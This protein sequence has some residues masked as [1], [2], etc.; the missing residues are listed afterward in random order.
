MK[1]TRTRAGQLGALSAALLL[2]A[3][4]GAGCS[5]GEP[6]AAPKPPEPAKAA[7][8]AKPT[9]ATEPAKP[10]APAKALTPTTVP[11]GEWLT[12]FD[13]KTLNGWK[14]PKE[15]DFS[16]AGKVEIK[17]GSLILREGV[18]FTGIAWE[19]AF[20]KE[21]FEIAYE[22]KRS[23]GIDIF[24]GCTVPVGDSHVTFVCG[25]WGD[26][27]VGLSSIDDRN[28]SDNEFTKV[29]SFKNDQWYSM[30]L[31]VTKEKI[32]AWIDDTQ[33]I[34]CKRE[35]HKFSIYPEL[36]PCRPV[37]FFSWSTEGTL[38][39]IDMKRLKAEK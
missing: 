3:G 1:M 27:V 7:E 31:R 24:C 23:S 9:E 17:D 22:A 29:M 14:A 6:V 38:R 15:D 34:D 21:D 28:A 37:G 26:S 10:A 4:L 36:G 13:G 5:E 18:P 8:P 33:V 32:E 16:L 30:R 20:P 11:P 35:G 39:N 19:D 12:L 2:L 25:G